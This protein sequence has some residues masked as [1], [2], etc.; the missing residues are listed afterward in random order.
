M[1]QTSHLY[2]YV[3]RAML[4]LRTVP[5][6]DCLTIVSADCFL[7][8]KVANTE[9]ACPFCSR[10]GFNVAYEPT[11][12]Q[13]SKSPGSHEASERLSNSNS[14]P[15]NNPILQYTTPE[16]DKKLRS[17]SFDKSGTPVASKAD[18]EAIEAEILKQR[19]DALMHDYSSSV[20]RPFRSPAVSRSASLPSRSESV[21]SPP[22]SRPELHRFATERT[23]AASSRRRRSHSREDHVAPPLPPSPYMTGSSFLDHDEGGDFF[24]DEDAHLLVA[25]QSLL[26]ADGISASSPT[27]PSLEQL[28][29]MMLMEVS[30]AN[31]LRKDAFSELFSVTGYPPVDE[32]GRNVHHGAVAN[33]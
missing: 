3:F 29:E 21:S 11:P 19:T 31:D 18:R 23:P 22:G 12:G 20:S 5:Q 10:D 4:F 30:R 9:V 7:Q 1:L 26:S 24:S 17:T 14:S 33:V 25:L 16:Q 32:G 6:L 13:S 2:R 28:E 8:L 15:G 27:M